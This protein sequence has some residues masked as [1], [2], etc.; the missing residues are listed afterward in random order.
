MSA[1]WQPTWLANTA[2][3]PTAVVIPTVFTGY[4]WRCTTGGTS[5]GTEP[6]WPDPTSGT[7]TITDGGVTWSVGTGFRQSVQA[8]IKSIVQTFA[9]ANPTIIRSV[10][11]VRPPSLA[12]STSLPV[13]YIGDMNESI[14]HVSGLRTRTIS[15]FSAYLVDQLGTIDDSND[16][17]NFAADVLTDL[18][19]LNYHAA[20]AI[21]IFQHT[22][23]SDFE[24]EEGSIRYPAL[25]FTFAETKLAEGRT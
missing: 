6:S 8:G 4:T 11:T 23:T 3:T 14:T 19:T 17:M 24:V 10:R 2:Y 12:G 7:T 13:F 20:S 16:R 5:A 15:G 9:T 18:F 22:G 25:E 1:I 21:S